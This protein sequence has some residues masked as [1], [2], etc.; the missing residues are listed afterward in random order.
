MINIIK[1]KVSYD[2]RHHLK[3]S[4]QKL[5]SPGILLALILWIIENISSFVGD[6]HLQTYG[7][8][9]DQLYLRQ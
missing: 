9:G 8:V 4:A 7:S 6:S 3:S 2:D 5:P 1:V